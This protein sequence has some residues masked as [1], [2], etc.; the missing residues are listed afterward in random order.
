M[1][2][3]IIIGSQSIGKSVKIRESVE[4]DK[5]SIRKLHQN[6]FDQSEGETE[7]GRA[8]CRERV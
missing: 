7:I 6:A 1:W 8:S 3:G 4:S 2:V 5:K